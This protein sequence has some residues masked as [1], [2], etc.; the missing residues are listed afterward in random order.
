MRSRSHEQ[1]QL[2]DSAQIVL[3]R[4]QQETPQLFTERRT[5]GLTH[6]IHL[7]PVHRSQIL[8]EHLRLGR[9]PRAITTFEHDEHAQNCNAPAR[10]CIA[11]SGAS[12][13]RAPPLPPASA[14]QRLALTKLAPVLLQQC[15]YGIQLRFG[16]TLALLDELLQLAEVRPVRRAHVRGDNNIGS[17]EL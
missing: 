16:S 2:G 10:S 15:K 6:T 5:S 4:L 11:K 9:L 1:V 13:R 12:E 3:A 17:F 8:G 7:T 14:L